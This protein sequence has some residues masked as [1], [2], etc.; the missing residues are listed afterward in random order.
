MILCIKKNNIRYTILQIQASKCNKGECAGA[1][2]SKSQ[3][4]CDDSNRG[5]LPLHVK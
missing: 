1:H 3:F 4:T 2:C 5:F